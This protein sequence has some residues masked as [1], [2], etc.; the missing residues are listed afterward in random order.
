MLRKFEP[1]FPG[2]M[3]IKA[4]TGSAPWQKIN[5]TLGVSKLIMGLNGRPAIIP[6]EFIEKLHARMDDQGQIIAP[7]MIPVGTKVQ[8]TS[9]PFAE[10]FA[11]VEACEKGERVNLLLSFMGRVVRTNLS[12]NEVKTA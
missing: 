1:L 10:W 8:I 4:K 3:F 6:S 7:Q 2:Y 11:E 12:L 5:S 9:G